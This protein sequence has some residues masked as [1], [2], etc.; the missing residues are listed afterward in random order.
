MEASLQIPVP[1]A[2]DSENVVTALE[3][4]ALFGNK[5]ES[6]EAVR[7]LKR[8]A[9]HAGEEG[10][11]TRA[12]ALARTAAELTD[13]LKRAPDYGRTPS[14]RPLPT[15]PAAPT[16]LRPPPPSERAAS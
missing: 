11:D 13:K 7:W 3:M 15:P 1:A 16:S 10:D 2:S 12:L 8:A 9:E 14:E 6:N 4:A 5:G